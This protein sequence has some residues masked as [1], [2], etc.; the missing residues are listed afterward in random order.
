MIGKVFE[1]LIV[2]LWMPLFE[3]LFIPHPLQCAYQK[4][5]GCT[6]ASLVQREQKNH[7]QERGSKVYACFLDSSKAFD[8]VWMDGLFYKLYNFGIKG[9]TW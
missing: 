2:D 1:R 8:T 4:G 6:Q 9:K 7:Y 5:K 3:D